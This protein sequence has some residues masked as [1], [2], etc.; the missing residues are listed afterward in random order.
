MKIRWI[1]LS[2]FVSMLFTIFGWNVFAYSVG[3]S[4]VWTPVSIS[5]AGAFKPSVSIANNWEYVVAW[6]KDSSVEAKIYNWDDTLKVN[7][8][9]I[10]SN[11]NL[12]TNSSSILVKMDP[13]NGNWIV[14]YHKKPTGWAD[15]D[16]YYRV[17]NRSWTPLINSMALSSE[18]LNQRNLFVDYSPADE[19]FTI[20]YATEKETDLTKEYIYVAQVPNS[21]SYIKQK[22]GPLMESDGSSYRYFTALR[23]H[24]FFLPAKNQISTNSNDSTNW[25][26]YNY[27]WD[28][29][30]NQYRYD[31]LGRKNVN[32]AS[33]SNNWLFDQNVYQNINNKLGWYSNKGFY[34]LTAAHYD[35]SCS[36]SWSYNYYFF[37]QGILKSWWFK[38]YN[39]NGDVYYTSCSTYIQNPN[40]LPSLHK[41][42][43]LFNGGLIAIFAPRNDSQYKE[44]NVVYWDWVDSSA[45]TTVTYNL[46]WNATETIS[47]V[48]VNLYWKIITVKWD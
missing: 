48:D 25:D 40:V 14:I 45:P 16:L 24:T 1:A 27:I 3:V 44:I 43:N 34:A 35:S 21:S 12:D 19:I 41:V 39:S 15:T 6:V 28:S 5:S 47:A 7:T 11:T 13:I 33:T 38:L 46:L 20:A 36:E 4:G 42:S 32:L 31:G 10:D 23:N 29:V 2:L 37:R 9:T 22:Q 17:Y 26:L 18:A 8:I 30:N